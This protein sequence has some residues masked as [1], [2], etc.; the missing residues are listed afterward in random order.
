MFSCPECEKSYSSKSGLWKHKQKIHLKILKCGY[1]NKQYKYSSQMSKHKETCKIKHKTKND[2]KDVN[3]QINKFLKTLNNH[4]INIDRSQLSN[5]L[6]TNTQNNNNIQNNIQNNINNVNIVVSLDDMD[7]LNVL[8]DKDQKKILNKRA[9]WLNEYIKLVFINKNYPGFQNFLIKDIKSAY[10]EIYDNDKEDYITQKKD[11]VLNQVL[12]MSINDLTDMINMHK[13]NIGKTTNKM[14][15]K[16]SDKYIKEYNDENSK[17][18]KEK[19]KDIELMLYNGRETVN[20]TVNL[21]K[22]EKIKLRPKKRK[23]VPK[24]INQ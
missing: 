17:F 15:K 21:V 2:E 8:S 14:A 6:N 1:C 24:I 23:L 12:G 19:T 10:C 22:H 20:E 13:E 16:S 11:D 5:C 7:V 4:G 9:Q 18:I 3:S